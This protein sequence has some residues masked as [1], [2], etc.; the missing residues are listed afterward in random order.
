MQNSPSSYKMEEEWILSHNLYRSCCQVPQM[1]WDNSL[2]RKA[3]EWADWLKEN[4]EGRPRHPES[5]QEKNKFLSLNGKDYDKSP[6]GQNIAWYWARNKPN[7]GS[8]ARSV[9]S[10][11]AEGE[12]YNPKKPNLSCNGCSP[13][14]GDELGHFTQLCWKDST[15]IGCGVSEMV[16]GNENSSVWV[17]NYFPAG[18]KLT[19]GNK[20][21]QFGDNVGTW[22]EYCGWDKEDNSVLPSGKSV[23]PIIFMI[24]G[25]G[26]LGGATYFLFIKKKP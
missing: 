1:E 26:I 7:Q 16:K 5:S 13:E 14:S 19:A 23:W 8:P 10:W 25:L 11:Y 21:A 15:K 3:Q 2:A 20:Y 17:C 22:E 18:N 12:F 4:S 24:L 9:A 6:L